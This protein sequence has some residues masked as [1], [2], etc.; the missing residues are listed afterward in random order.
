M[1]KDKFY[2]IVILSYM[3]D[4]IVHNLTEDCLQLQECFALV[5]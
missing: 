4:V 2:E 5:H 1:M 3:I